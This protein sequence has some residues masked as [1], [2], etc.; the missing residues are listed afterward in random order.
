M[1]VAG[2][3]L[4]AALGVGLTACAADDPAADAFNE[5][6]QQYASA[7]GRVVEIP[8]ADRGKPIEFGGTTEAGEKYQSETGTVTV[9]NFWYAACGPCRIE[10]KDLESV[11]QKYQD[12]VNFVGVNIVDQAATA[13]AFAKKY[14]VTY[15]SIIDASSGQAKLAFAEVTPIQAPPVTLVLDAEGRVAARIIGPI[16]GASVLSTLIDDT[17]AESA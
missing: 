9:V 10:A 2:L 14:G 5:G 6:G 12:D 15:P 11:W 16:D 17:L 13:K 1:R 4:A 8:E 3:V 7:S